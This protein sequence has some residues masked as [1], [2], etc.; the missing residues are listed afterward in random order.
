MGGDPP[1]PL[2]AQNTITYINIQSAGNATDFGDLITA[3]ENVPAGL[4]DIN[5]G[6]G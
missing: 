3:R 2:S 1:S 4:C 5:G 6:I